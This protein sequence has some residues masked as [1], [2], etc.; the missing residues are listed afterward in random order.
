MPPEVTTANSQDHASVP[1]P[2]LTHPR[3]R[4]TLSVF[5]VSWDEPGPYRVMVTQVAYRSPA[6][7]H[8]IYH[9][10]EPGQDGVSHPV[11]SGAT[12]ASPSRQTTTICCAT[13]YRTALSWW[14]R[15]RPQAGTGR[16]MLDGAIYI[17]NENSREDSVFYHGK[18]GM[19]SMSNARNC[20]LVKVFVS[21]ARASSLWI[22][23]RRSPSRVLD[24][25]PLTRIRE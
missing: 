4:R 20:G 1:P 11:I 23:G 9:P 22:A 6:P 14:P 3:S 5:V 12:G 10:S 18:L 17:S 24:T 15:T 21:V 19:A 16:E 25:C 8:T 2:A 13:G 7:S